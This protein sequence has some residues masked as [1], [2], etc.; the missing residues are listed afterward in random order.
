MSLIK[1]LAS[2]VAGVASE[3]IEDKDKRLEAETQL[4]ANQ[5]EV[6]KQDAQS[7]HWFQF[8]WR[9]FIG[10][11]CGF[12]LLYNGVFSQ[13]FGLATLD[14]EHTMQVLFAILGLSGYRTIEKVRKET[15]KTQGTKQET[16][17]AAQ[18]KPKDSP[19]KGRWF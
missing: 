17:V 3:F 9:P 2:S 18:S 19:K 16:P 8:G 13:I 6:N 15:V 5:I 7:E 12:T 4:A 10:W 1:D 14:S 11:V